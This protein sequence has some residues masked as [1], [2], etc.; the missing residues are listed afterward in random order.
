[1]TGC[2]KT[3]SIDP[4][5]GL[6]TTHYAVDANVVAKAEKPVEGTITL[7]TVLATIWPDLIPPTILMILAS[8]F[9]T[10]LKIKPKLTAAQTRAQIAYNASAAT[11][12]GIEEFKKAAPDQWDKLCQQLEAIK[13][14]IIKPEDALII[15]NFI[16]G[17][18]GLPPKE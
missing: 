1:M 5:T 7:L 17:L 12:L 4:N 6:A 18:R 14:K 15:E 16:R 3:I 10:W 9:G 2:I 13:A 11:I 8:I